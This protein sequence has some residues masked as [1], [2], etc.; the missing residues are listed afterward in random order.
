MHECGIQLAG[1]SAASSR[2]PPLE[3]GALGVVGVFFRRT[4]ETQDRSLS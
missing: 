1:A 4:H 3:I 2:G